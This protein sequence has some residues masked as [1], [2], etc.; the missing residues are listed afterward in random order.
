LREEHR[1][2]VLRRIFE[3]KGDEVTGEWRKIHNQELNDLY[4]FTVVTSVTYLE[5]PYIFFII[6]QSGYCKRWGSHNALLTYCMDL[7]LEG[8]KITKLE[9]KHVALQV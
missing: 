5:L 1:L 4:C 9:S 8:L 3:P 2:R 6:V 7:T